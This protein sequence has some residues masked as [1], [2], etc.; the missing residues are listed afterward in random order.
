MS[1]DFTCT[2]CQSRLQRAGAG[3]TAITYPAQD[4]P[5]VAD[6]RDELRR[7]PARWNV[8]SVCIPFSGVLCGPLLGMFVFDR[9]RGGNSY[10]PMELIAPALL[11]WLTFCAVGLVATSMA[12]LRNERLWGLTAFGFFL[13]ALPFLAWGFSLISDIFRAMDLLRMSSISL[14]PAL[15]ADLHSSVSQNGLIL[16]AIVLLFALPVGA[17]VRPIM[18]SRVSASAK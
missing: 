13:N 16:S 9:L 8:V 7:Q 17:L 14:S 1:F 3:T 2:P 18:G 4:E 15:E 12:L 5:P 10:H 11:G 6:G